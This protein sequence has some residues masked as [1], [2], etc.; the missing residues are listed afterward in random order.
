VFG[1]TAGPPLHDP[2]AVAAAL[3]GTGQHEI[4][5]FDHDP[6]LP[7]AARRPERFEVTV[8]TEGTQEE[9]RKGAQTG[10]TIAKLLPSGQDGVRIPR[11]LDIT[12]FW[13]ELEACCQRADEANARQGR[14]L[15]EL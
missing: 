13:K 10:R 5:F 1:I 11:G 14:E 15:S 2:V 6:H 4:P 8:V 7:A 3:V 12:R 9:G